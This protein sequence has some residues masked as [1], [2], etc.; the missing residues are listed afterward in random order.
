MEILRARP[1]EYDAIVDLFRR[2]DFALKERRWFDWKHL[3]NPFGEELVFR[4]V[5]DGALVGTVALMAQPFRHGDRR[6]TAIQA[7]DGLMGEEI[8]GKRL[9][10]DVMAFVLGTRPD[11]VAG[12]TFHLGFASKPGSMRALEN[13]GWRKLAHFHL[14]TCLLTPARLRALPGGRLLAALVSPLWGLVRS[15]LFAGATD[16]IAVEET[17]RF[18]AD[19]NHLVPEDRVAGD[20][21]A[22]L[23]NWRVCANPR[24]RMRVFLLREAGEITG[25]AVCKVVPGSWE[26]VEFRTAR[27]DRRAFGAFLRHLHRARLCDTVGVWLLDGNLMADVLPGAGTVTRRI[28]GAMFVHGIEAAG[29]PVDPAGWAGGYLDSDW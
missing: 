6:L 15:L 17:D 23:L 16:A 11:G 9:F 13:A 25:Y 29:L 4:L 10:N 12:D 14:K 5:E 7:V 22:A 18:P 3:E 20:R 28:G 8:R 19:M 24:D 1:D 2:Y 26:V 21:S 27:R